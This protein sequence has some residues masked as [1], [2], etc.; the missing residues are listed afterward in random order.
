MGKRKQHVIE[1]YWQTGGFMRER[2]VVCRCGWRCDHYNAGHV[3]SEFK[4]H[5]AAEGDA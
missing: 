1:R 3:K 2:H 4:K 5:Q